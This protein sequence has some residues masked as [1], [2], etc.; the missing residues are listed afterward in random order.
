MI[1]KG[2][3]SK[4]YDNKSGNESGEVMVHVHYTYQQCV[5]SV[6]EVSS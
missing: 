1:S 5:L 2:S 4:N 6:F 3:D